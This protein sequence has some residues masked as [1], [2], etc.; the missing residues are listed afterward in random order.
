MSIALLPRRWPAR[1]RAAARRAEITASTTVA[2][3]VL[4]S[5]TVLS[6]WLV[7]YALVA[8]GFQEQHTQASLY[9]RIRSELAAEVAPLAPPIADGAPVAVMD[10]SVAGLRHVVIVQGTSSGD[11]QDGPGHRVDTVLPGQS[12][13]SVVFGKGVTFGGPFAGITRLRPGDPIDVTTAAGVQHFRVLDQRKGGDPLPAP[14]AADHGRLTLVTSFGSGWRSGWAPTEVVYVDADL[15]GNAAAPPAAPSALPAS[16]AALAGDSSAL[17]P[18]VLWL[19]LLVL[20]SVGIT[21]ARGHWGVWQVW[22]AGAPVALALVWVIT[23]TTARLLP[24][25]V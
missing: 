15:Q 7:F 11:L 12:G 22:L 20:V 21:W 18:L 2:L 17:T 24:N 25:L 14:V 3:T 6:L 23:E 9:G 19:E 13:V 5:I 16:Q 8:S 10:A 4:G 1:S